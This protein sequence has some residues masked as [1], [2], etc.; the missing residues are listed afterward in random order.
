MFR[1]AVSKCDFCGVL[2]PEWA[3]PAQEFYHKVRVDYVKTYIQGF[4]RDEWAACD[5]CAALIHGGEDRELAV[6]V[7][8]SPEVSRTITAILFRDDLINKVISL[9]DAFR[10]NRLQGP[11]VLIC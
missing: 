8:Q 3:F 5:A 9:H 10:R 1:T 11:P 4:M 7:F 2:N 6:R